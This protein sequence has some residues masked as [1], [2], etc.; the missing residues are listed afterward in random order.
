MKKKFVFVLLVFISGSL[1]ANACL[2][3][4]GIDEKGRSHDLDAHPPHQIHMDSQFY[5][6]QLIYT[7]TKLTDARSTERFQDLSDY[8][9][10]LIRLGRVEEATPLLEGLLADRP[11]EYQVIAN[12]AV[13]YELEG[14]PEAALDCLEESVKINPSSH[15]GSEWIHRQILCE[16]IRQRNGSAAGTGSGILSAAAADADVYSR[17]LGYQLQERVP[18]TTSP[19]QYFSKVL[20]EIADYYR[21]T[22]S[23]EWAM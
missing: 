9:A 13:A 10:L 14:Y 12:L 22:I 2:N 3:Y 11:Q 8:A 16:K 19:D 20:E 5:V 15:F 21:V 7:E 6:T 23:L 18:L 17:H 1:I 4:Y